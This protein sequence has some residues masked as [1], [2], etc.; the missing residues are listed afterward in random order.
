MNTAVQTTKDKPKTI[1]GRMGFFDDLEIEE[2]ITDTP[3]AVVDVAQDAGEALLDLGKAILGFGEENHES[4]QTKHFPSNGEIGNFQ[5]PKPEAQVV[6]DKKKAEAKLAQAR[7]TIVAQQEVINTQQQKIKKDRETLRIVGSAMSGEEK[8]KLLHVSLDYDEE[9][10]KN[11]YHMVNLR[12][13]LKEQFEEKEKQDKAQSLPIIS[14]RAPGA[15]GINL[16]KV[17][18]GGQAQLSTT[19]GG[20][21]G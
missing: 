9:H 8:R 20:G 19:G 16:N 5:Q 7:Y 11:P 21:I 12:Q 2:F 17:A 18:E 14:K 6:V 3:K 1:G 15:P 4:K 13:K 10:L